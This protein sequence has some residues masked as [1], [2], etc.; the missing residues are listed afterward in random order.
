MVR[1]YLL[2][3][4][5]IC[6]VAA[7]VVLRADTAEV[8]GV[9]VAEISNSS[10][11]S[12]NLILPHQDPLLAHYT[13]HLAAEQSVAVSLEKVDRHSNAWTSSVAVGYWLEGRPEELADMLRKLA[14]VFHPITLSEQFAEDERKILLREYE[15]RYAGKPE[16]LKEAATSEFL[17]HGNMLAVDV[18]GTPEKIMAMSYDQ[19]KAFH[20]ETH[21]PEFARLVVTGNITQAQL[22]DALEEVQFPELAGEKKL[23]TAK[24]FV[25]AATETRHFS[26]SAVELA[27]RFIWRKVVKLQDQLGFDLLIL[28]SNF[29]RSILESNL[30]GG[31]AGPLRYDAL[32]AKSFSLAILP[33]DEGHVVLEFVGE[34]D[35][36][37]SF[38]Q[39][40]QAFEAALAASANGIPPETF[41]RMRDRF[42]AGFPALDDLEATSRWNAETVL[43]RVSAL[44][45][46]KAI[47]LLHE[48]GTSL[49][50][51]DIEKLLRTL[52]GP[53]R[54]AIANLGKDTLP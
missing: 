43:D 15:S 5:A 54:L 36:G 16:Q 28:Q 35:R 38:E 32:I 1:L 41:K 52:A 27:P 46:P 51:S 29:L 26:N 49:Q 30:S 14:V 25:L 42:E 3:A 22:V 37:V 44:R 31:L 4:M 48:M 6:A 23:A 33:I 20:A 24:P 21:R 34:P 12:V 10:R 45:E 40:R 7:V 18:I 13:E 50:A 11:V 2:A 39:L 53:G 17:Y 47:E 19:A 8:P 9:R